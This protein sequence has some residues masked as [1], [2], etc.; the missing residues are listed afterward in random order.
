[1]T[2]GGRRAVDRLTQIQAFDDSFRRHRED[3]ADRG[4]DLARAD[5]FAA[6]RIHVN[7]HRFRDTDRVGKLDFTVVRQTGRH[8]VFRD[9]ACHVR[10]RAVNF[11]RVFTG[12]RAAA[13]G[14]PAAVG[15]DDDLTARQTAVAM[16]TTDDEVARRVDVELDVSFVQLGRNTR[17]DD[18]RNDPVRDLFLADAGAVLGGNDDRRDFHRGHAV[19]IF[20]RDLTLGVG[21]KP[22]HFT[23]LASFGQTVH[24]AV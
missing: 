12:E 24:D 9:V 2:A 6:V 17:K 18:V 4:F 16:R 7:A 13:V 3:L 21:K 15:V 22:I 19:H 23:L 10:G 20:D 8:D 5:F 14:G 11:R 1:M